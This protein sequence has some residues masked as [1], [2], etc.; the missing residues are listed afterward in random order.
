MSSSVML[1]RVDL[2]RT[3]ISEE[4][5]SSIIRVTRMGGLGTTL[6]VTSNGSTLQRNIWRRYFPPKRRFF[7]VPR[8]VTSQ[9]TAFFGMSITWDAFR[10]YQISSQR[11]SVLIWTEET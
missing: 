6:A 5:I 3:C 1:H 4:N 9:E 2:V 7:Q 10:D 11:D 8:G